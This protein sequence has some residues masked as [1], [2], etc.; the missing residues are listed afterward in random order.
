V[1][2][3]D[4][5]VEWNGVSYSMDGEFHD[6]SRDGTSDLRDVTHLSNQAGLSARVTRGPRGRAETHSTIRSRAS[7]FKSLPGEEEMVMPRD[8]HGRPISEW[9][10][11]YDPLA[12]PHPGKS[13]P[14]RGNRSDAAED[15]LV[16][17]LMNARAAAR[18]A[19]AAA[20]K[21]AQR[22]ATIAP[23]VPRPKHQLGEAQYQYYGRRPS[24]PSTL[25]TPDTASLG[26]AEP[27]PAIAEPP[28]PSGRRELAAPFRPAE[29]IASDLLLARGDVDG[30]DT[31]GQTALSWASDSGRADVV[32]YL[33]GMG[34]HV[35]VR[36]HVG[37]TALVRACRKGH[38]EVVGIL[39]ARGA[40]T[41]PSPSL[42]HWVGETPLFAAIRNSH[43][44]TAAL[45]RN[46]GAHI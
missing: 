14:S 23:P 17:D 44:E 21:A 9:R 36:D 37:E 25:S 2:L 18:N 7:T 6:E 43:L 20:L 12:A 1:P 39:L 32:E 15:D 40:D 38:T 5:A 26:S 28:S 33:L 42:G 10:D 29:E 19:A 11:T 30:K 31:K 46:T 4:E 41:G 13:P 35:D 24:Y 45:L 3:R 8:S 16:A 34:A 22:G 27:L